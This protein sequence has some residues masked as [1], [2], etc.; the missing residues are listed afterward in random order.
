MHRQLCQQLVKPI[1]Y[2]CFFSSACK[3]YNVGAAT[4]AANIAIVIAFLFN[5]FLAI[6]V[7]LIVDI[8]IIAVGILNWLYI[9]IVI[10]FTYKRYNVGI[11]AIDMSNRM[12]IFVFIFRS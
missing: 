7:F 1:I 11:A 5:V 12:H 9:P 6:F 3:N 8:E 10:F 2:I 4:L